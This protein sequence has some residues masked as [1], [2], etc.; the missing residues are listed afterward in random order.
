MLR[1]LWR[2]GDG[3]EEMLNAAI[4]NASEA[5]AR[6][7]LDKMIPVRSFVA[8]NN[9]LL[10]IRGT[11]SVRY[12]RYA[13]GKYAIGLEFSGGNGWRKSAAEA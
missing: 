7:R 1:I 5:G 12:C 6:L 2:D 8:C 3:R 4:E 11:G 10:G 9:E 13:K